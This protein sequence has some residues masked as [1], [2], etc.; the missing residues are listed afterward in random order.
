M[1]N[2]RP[3]RFPPPARFAASFLP[4]VLLGTMLTGVGS[5][6]ESK[7]D[8]AKDWDFKSADLA[9]DWTREGD[10]RTRPESVVVKNGQVHI[11]TRAETWDRVKI[12]TLDRQ[13][14]PGSYVWRV[15]LPTMDRGDMASIGAFIYRDDGH[16]MDFEIGPGK[17][18]V[19]AK[20]KTAD[21][22]LVCYCTN[23]KFP[24]STTTVNLK[25]GTWHTLAMDLSPQSDGNLRVRWSIDGH[26]VKELQ[27]QIPATTR[28]GIH[29][30]VENLKF[31]GDHQ[32]LQDHHAAFD[33]VIHT[34][35]PK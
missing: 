5:A 29:C 17:D 9:P 34:P 11:T 28:F 1:R 30:S 19:R 35:R 31:L 6:A 25:A 12:T 20:L 22:E 2:P 7:P 10:A 8:T 24:Y 18:A 26:Q 27:T 21:N 13:F 23:Q 32:P 4:R 14:G 16:E 3:S 15:H 33:R